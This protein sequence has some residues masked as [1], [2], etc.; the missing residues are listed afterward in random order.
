MV[1]GPISMA[2]IGVITLL[3]L[4][5]VMGGGPRVFERFMP[6]STLVWLDENDGFSGMFNMSGMVSMTSGEN[7]PTGDAAK[8][9]NAHMRDG[10]SGIRGSNKVVAMAQGQVAFVSDVITGRRVS[11][12]AYSPGS[13]E[14]LTPVTGCAFTPPSDGAFVGHVQSTGRSN[15]WVNLATY[16]D[17]ELAE[18]VQKFVRVY[19]KSGRKQIYGLKEFSFEA[20]DVVVTE[21]QKPTYLVL[22]ASGGRPRLWNI[23][24]APGATLERVVLLGG[25]QAGVINVD[26]S[27]PVE[28]M[29]TDARVSC[30][31]P[32]PSYPLNAGAQLYQ[33]L[34]AG[35]LSQEEADETLG[36]L[37][38][39]NAAWDAW[40]RKSFGVSAN[41]TMAGNWDDG[42]IAAVGPLP[43]T[44]EGKAKFKAVTDGSARITMDT[45]VEY[46]ALKAE[47][48][49]YA[50]RVVAI[51][52]AFAGGNLETLRLEDF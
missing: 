35:H 26:P 16:G 51:A 8:D 39:Q 9:P 40:F 33:V 38:A 32:G 49:D 36:R 52:T 5:M 42:A 19:R 4:A 44:P 12:G 48:V 1:R 24:L 50:S 10:R 25:D 34:E 45:Y 47:G 6:E 31:L 27:V 21:T 46:P 2:V 23:Q 30:Q 22:S 11:S 28:V 41:D 20:F 13:A 17:E 43:A 37:A 14:A 18:E 29:L 15:I 3:M 7:G